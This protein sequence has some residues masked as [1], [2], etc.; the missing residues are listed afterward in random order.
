VAGT[1][2]SCGRYYE[3][4][5][6]DTCADISVAS[7]ITLL[8][9]LSLNQKLNDQC[10]NLLSGY[11]Y[12]VAAV[13]GTATDATPTASSVVTPTP[14]QE[15]LTKN[16][17][18]FYHVKS[19]DG[20]YDIAN[21]NGISLDEFYTYNPAVGKDCSKLYPDTYVCVSVAQS[22]MVSVSF[23]TTYS[24]EWG[25]SV[26]VVG[27]LPELGEWD[28][29]NALMLTGSSGADSTTNWEVSADLPSDTHVSYKFIKLQTD[30]TPVWEEGSNREFDTSSCGGP[31]LQEGGKWQDGSP[32]C[33]AVEVVFQTQARTSYG[34]AVYVVGS[35]PSLGQWSASGAV[36]L[37]ADEYSES[38]PVW[39]GTI[40]LAV[41]QDVEY[42]FIKIGLDG[43][44]TWEADPN[45][46][47][48]VPA[49]CSTVATQ[50]GQWHG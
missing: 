5:T 25:E 26:W 36:S 30:G 29:S 2:K 22:C 49:D 7:S 45:R 39:K 47:L 1:T 17:N 11:A 46:Q 42:K 35:V 8:E 20:C 23:K 24:T 16:C 34:E 19:G 28:T 44:F 41:G 50:G 15:G 12:C 3:V 21:D 38:N 18:V 27:S 32:S 9:F 13:N 40:T 33:T 14:I 31:K 6:G 37:S 43:T 10:S 4:K 48:T